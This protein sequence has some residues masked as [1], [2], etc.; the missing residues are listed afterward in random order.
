M[1]SFSRPADPAKPFA[2]LLRQPPL[3]AVSLRHT[4]HHG[5]RL[6]DPYAWLR[7]KNWQQVI[8]DP[9]SVPAEIG[10]Y[11]RQ[12]NAYTA[13]ALRPLAGLQKALIAQMRGR[14]R[15]DEAEPPVRD[16]AFFYY[17]RFR[18]RQQYPLFCRRAVGAKREQIL[19]DGPKEA[20]GHAY[21][22]IGA[23]APSP[24]HALMAWAADTTGSESY[25]IRVRDLETGKDHDRLARTSG[26]VVWGRDNTF[27]YY[28][29]LDKSQRPHRVMRHRLGEKQAADVEIYNEENS[30]WFVSLDCTQDDR[31]G[32][33]LVHDHETSEVLLLDLDDPSEVPVPVFPR[34]QG[35]EYDIEHHAGDLIIRTNHGGEAGSKT[36]DFRIVVLPLGQ[37]DIAGARLLVAETPGRM[38]ESLHV[39]EDWLIWSDL[40]E[41]GPRIH[42]RNWTSGAEQ[43]FAPRAAVG[44][45]A[46][47]VGLEYASDTLRLSFSSP[48]EPE[49]TIERNLRTGKETVLK[50]QE[51][52]S[53]HDP[54]LYRVERA[55]ATSHDGAQVPVTILARK[56]TPRD[57]TAPA[58]LYGYGAYGSALEADFE[59]ERLSLVDHG[60]VYVLAHTRGGLEKGFGWYR[61][62]KRENKINTFLDFIAV[63]D[64]LVAE[65]YAAPGRIVAHGVSAGGMLMGAIANR[66]GG[67]FAGIVA[68]VPFVDCLN[69]ILDR[70]LPLTPP[71]WVEWG[72]PIT[73]KATFETMLGYSPYENIA[74]KPYPP[75]LVT[76]GLSDPRVTYW[77]PAKFVARLRATMTGG[78]PILLHTNMGAGHGGASGRFE[79]LA[80]IAR[81]FAFA[82]EVTGTVPAAGEPSAVA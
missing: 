68:E 76:A 19:L 62:G 12:E 47:M 42:V 13:E 66:A 65:G 21:F 10:S 23:T 16:G 30:G 6:E 27:F 64:F 67:K 44:D 37:T 60:F 75:M 26:D 72:N 40:G 53:G 82:M 17:E 25:V 57:G 32:F 22:D 15:E 45:I 81:V 36:P 49:V 51:V 79:Q 2:H 11:L 50:V 38:L 56:E 63:A 9:R 58:L 3:A 28:I 39:L 46:G 80:D 35:I 71:E 59:T 7:A 77:E 74:A 78:G 18:K 20:R 5:V 69:T 8:E 73:D 29:A 31:Y 54:A 48:M 33:I 55:F 61:D 1:T 70:T 4:R 52:P 41:D 34:V 43:V 14:I 24:S